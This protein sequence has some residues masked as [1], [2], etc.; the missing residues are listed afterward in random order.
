MTSVES[1]TN[2]NTKSKEEILRELRLVYKQKCID[3]S[4]QE[5]RLYLYSFYVFLAY[6][7]R[8]DMIKRNSLKEVEISIMNQLG[9]YKPPR[10]Y[11]GKNRLISNYNQRPQWKVE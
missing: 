1:Y 4:S 6:I 5:N 2:N 10:R 9:C 3:I 8:W 7:N 11:F